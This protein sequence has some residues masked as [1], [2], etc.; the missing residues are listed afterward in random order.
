VGLAFVVFRRVFCK[1]EWRVVISCVAVRAWP[2]RSHA[3]VD[4]D[5]P[6]GIHL[7]LPCVE[8]LLTAV[9]LYTL[10]SLFILCGLLVRLGLLA[11]FGLLSLVGLFTLLGLLTLFG[12]STL[13]SPFTL[14]GLSALLERS[15]WNLHSS[16]FPPPNHHLR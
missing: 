15:R 1:R 16:N 10:L 14:L 7:L 8:K 5:P 2:T 3:F 12:L 11:F 6:L 9:W 4:I 13:F